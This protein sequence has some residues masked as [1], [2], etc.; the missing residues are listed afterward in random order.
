[1]KRSVFRRRLREE[2]PALLLTAAL[3]A[4]GWGLIWHI[5]PTDLGKEPVG[6]E[7]DALYTMGVTKAYGDRGFS[8][9]WSAPIHWLGAP[10]EAQ[11]GDLP[12]ED[13]MLFSMGMVARVVG[14]VASVNLAYLMAAVLAAVSDIT[15]PF[16]SPGR[17]WPRAAIRSA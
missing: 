13:V 15:Y 12:F 2:L 9:L 17:P 4:L 5:G 7:W 1:M 3:A 10:F 11:W 6:Y 8:S 14:V 16:P